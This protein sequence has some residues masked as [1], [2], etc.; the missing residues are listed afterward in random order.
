MIGKNDSMI[1]K[2]DSMT[3]K[4]NSVIGRSENE[5]KCVSLEVVISV[6]NSDYK[7]DNSSGSAIAD[8]RRIIRNDYR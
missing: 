8:Y 6:I 2:N 1:G 4:G 7:Y 3:R 5:D